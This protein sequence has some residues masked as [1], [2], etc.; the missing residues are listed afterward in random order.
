MPMPYPAVWVVYIRLAVLVVSVVPLMLILMDV[1][2]LYV[3]TM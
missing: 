1:P 3:P 2:R